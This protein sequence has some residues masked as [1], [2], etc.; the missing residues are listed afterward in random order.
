MN[1]IEIDYPNSMGF[2]GDLPNDVRTHFIATNDKEK[3]LLLNKL[4]F[5]SNVTLG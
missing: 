3:V 1:L 2:M 4:I 5:K